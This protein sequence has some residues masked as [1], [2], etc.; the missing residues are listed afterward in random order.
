MVGNN[1]LFINT[2]IIWLFLFCS[3]FIHNGYGQTQGSLLW[4]A[5]IGNGF[6]WSTPVVIN[7]RVFMQD[8]DG[9]MTCYKASDG[10]KVWF[11]HVAEAW[12][13][14]SPVY[15]NGKLFMLAGKT[16]Y[17]LNPEDGTVEKEFAADDYI[18]SQS[19][20][21]SDKMV[22]FASYSTLYAIDA[23]TFS[24]VWSKSIGSANIII[25]KDILYVL[26]DKLY[27]LNASNGTESWHMDPPQGSGFNIGA[28]SGIILAAFS[29]YD[30]STSSTKLHSYRLSSTGGTA[31]TLIWSADMGSSY[32][33]YSPPA[34][35][36]NTVYATSREGVLRAFALEGNGTPLW[37]KT[38]RSSGMACALPIAV[39]GKVFIQGEKADYS[40][41]LVCL[42]GSN[43]TTL[44]QTGIE[45]MGI[46]WGEPVLVNNVIYLAADHMGGLYA[47][48][49]GTVNG[50]WYMIKHNPDLSGSDNGWTPGGTPPVEPPC[51]AEVTTENISELNLLREFRDR[52][53]SQS[54]MGRE[55]IKL[56]Y[57]HAKEI[58]QLLIKDSQLKEQT[59]I[60]LGRI[61]PEVEMILMGKG[62]EFSPAL[63]NEL[64]D[65]LDQVQKKAGHELMTVIERLKGD[66]K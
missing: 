13:T 48:N 4:N 56:Y 19:P 7:D 30:Y 22:Y 25:S 36:G 28:I 44:W 61:I 20:A 24:L 16:I 45:G 38:V 26:A 39:D 14:N 23:D 50:N 40:M 17:R 9:G 2:V 10:Q 15:R 21:V 12:P 31:P 33:D 18:G 55:Y 65:F 64:T 46:A 35:Y 42:D 52:V 47:F 11:R 34:I 53:L 66:I 3:L 51:P 32:S 29:S 8:Q 49:T 59:N 60:L 54:G 27:G 63:R 1:R 43:G 41:S 37:E 62:K 58:A 5:E 6:T 57:G